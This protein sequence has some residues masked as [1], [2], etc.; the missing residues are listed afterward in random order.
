MEAHGPNFMVRGHL[1]T[2]SISKTYLETL[3][4]SAQMFDFDIFGTVVFTKTIK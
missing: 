1:D 3:I 2:L 4:E